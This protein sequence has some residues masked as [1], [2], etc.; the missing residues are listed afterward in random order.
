MAKKNKTQNTQTKEIETPVVEEK[1]KVETPVKEVKQ[2]KQVKPEVAEL[3]DEDS[4]LLDKIMVF[5]GFSKKKALNYE[6]YTRSSKPILN[7]YKMQDLV[8][9]FEE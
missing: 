7:S 3:S 1:T 6:Y 4:E 9:V 2:V 8:K 5:I